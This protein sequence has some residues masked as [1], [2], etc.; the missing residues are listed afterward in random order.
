MV[1]PRLTVDEGII[2]VRRLLPRC[3]FD[4]VRANRGVDCLENYTKKFDEKA[5]TFMNTPL[6]NWASHG[7]DAFRTMAISGCEELEQ[8]GGLWIPRGLKDS[9]DDDTQT[10]TDGEFDVFE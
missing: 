4:D 8:S 10:K 7:S 2:R 9:E 5:K 1:S 6:H 3:R